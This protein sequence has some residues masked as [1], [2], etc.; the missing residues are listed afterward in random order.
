LN[1]NYYS[2]ERREVLDLIPNTPKNVLELGCGDGVFGSILKQNYKCHVTGIDMHENSII[3]AR[4]KID[5]AYNA[6]IEDFDFF[7][8][9]K[10]D[11]IVANDLLE[12]LRDPWRVVK[13]L[14]ENLNDSGYFVASIPNI[15]YYKIFK[16]LFLKGRWDY[17]DQGVLDRTHLRFFTK[18]TMIDLFESSQ[19]NVKAVY[20]INEKKIKSW[21]ILNKAL[22]AAFPEL[23]TLQFLIIAQKK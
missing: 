6:S 19:Y 16:G 17:V 15:R 7:Q 10:Y 18:A 13:I 8:L 20:P 2:G 5:V 14:R 22:Q 1:N 23:F 4:E 9:D 12:H 21:Q 11:L 3:K